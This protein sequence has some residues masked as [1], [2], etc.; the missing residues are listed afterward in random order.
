MR[1]KRRSQPVTPRV[2][3]AGAGDL[4]CGERGSAAGDALGTRG[5]GWR[6][7]VGAGEGAARDTARAVG[8][9]GAVMLGAGRT[10]ARAGGETGEAE[11]DLEGTRALGFKTAFG[12]TAAGAGAAAG[13]R[14][15]DDAPA[16]AA[17]AF[18]ACRIA[19][20]SWTTRSRSASGKSAVGFQSNFFDMTLI[21]FLF[22]TEVS[23]FRRFTSRSSTGKSVI[24]HTGPSALRLAGILS[25][26]S[27]LHKSHLSRNRRPCARPMH[28]RADLDPENLNFCLHGPKVNLTTLMLKVN[29]KSPKLP[30]C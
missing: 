14:V 20:Y 15:P 27:H 29:F 18:W 17:D 11:G 25:H 6:A 7:G 19:T 10:G 22:D 21:I 30:H 8:S 2:F 3:G 24:G 23:P 1:N 28:D 9:R 5:D 16:W 4:P 13:D 26:K 12:V